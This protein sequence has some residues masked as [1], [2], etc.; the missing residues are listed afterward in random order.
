MTIQKVLLLGGGGFVG[1]AIANRLADLGITVTI[2]SRR[3][4]RQRA[5]LALP[6]VSLVQ[7]NIHDPAQLDSLMEGQ[8]AV[9]NLVGI[10][11]SRDFK[12]PYS[13]DFEQAHVELVKKIVAASQKGGIKRILHISA[14]RA[15]ADAPSEYLRSK[16]AGEAIVKNSGLE[17]TIFRPSVI[18]GA[19]DSFLNTFARLL[20]IMPRFYLGYGHAK[21]QP[22]HIG[23]VAEAF[24]RALSDATTFG[25]TYDLVGPKVYTL[26]QLVEYVNELTG[27]RKTIK[28]LPEVLALLQA[29]ILWLAP[30]PMLSPDNLRSMEVDSVAPDA[31]FPFGIK[32]VALE[33]VAP[34]YLLGVA[35]KRK[36][37]NFRYKAGR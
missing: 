10:L 24:V 5:V 22:V 28:D 30:K 1:T 8:D 9:I 29:G 11:H 16:A 19:G 2:P 13:K 25:K 36:L 6:N 26:R 14:L 3:R 23:D 32:P 21:F 15:A 35:I 7:A 33:A 31:E 17:Y 12:L 4:E 27:A 20:K 18:F 37:D 34:N